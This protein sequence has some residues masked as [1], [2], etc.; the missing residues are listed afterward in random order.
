MS[1]KSPKTIGLLATVGLMSATAF[2]AW[3]AEK[4]PAGTSAT[5]NAGAG[6][7]SPSAANASADAARTNIQ[8]PQSCG[9]TTLTAERF[10]DLFYAIASHGNL[11]DVDFIE[12]TL[13]VQFKA[14]TATEGGIPNPHRKY[15]VT[16]SIFGAPIAVSLD[17]NDDLAQQ[18][19]RRFIGILRFD[20]GRFAD[21]LRAP[22]STLSRRFNGPFVPTVIPGVSYEAGLGV[23][24][25]GYSGSNIHAGFSY[26]TADELVLGAAVQQNF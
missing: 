6:S 19:V 14:S 1:L 25:P 16:D 7:A 21:C 18:K 2:P 9:N 5:T 23:N 15:Y 4:A 10:A 26:R 3:A 20:F 11:L 12:Q 22:L 13:Q 17:V 8:P 24:F